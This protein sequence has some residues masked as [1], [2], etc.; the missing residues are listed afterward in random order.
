MNKYVTEI[1][2]LCPKDGMIKQYAGPN[3]E[4]NN[5]LEAQEWLEENGF[6]YCKVLGRLISTINTPDGFVHEEIEEEIIIPRE[7]WN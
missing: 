1:Q 7:R 4:A 2:A 3:V 5:A 6:G